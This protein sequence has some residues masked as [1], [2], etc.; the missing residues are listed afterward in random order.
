MQFLFQYDIVGHSGEDYKVGLIE[1]EKP[2]KNNKERLSAV[3]VCLCLEKFCYKRAASWQNQQNDWAPNEDSDQP[4]HPP[5][6]IRVFLC[7]KYGL[8]RTQ[9]FFM[10]TAKTLIG[11][12]RCPS[13]F[14]SSLGAHAILL[15]LSWGGSKL[16]CIHFTSYP[17]PLTGLEE[18]G[19]LPGAFWAELPE[20]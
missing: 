15:V 2:P 13:W 3:K 7:A 18:V 17:H 19:G 14:E 16:F 11:L 6:L 5:S 1:F 20:A 8:L 12:G 10:W 4:G 9:A